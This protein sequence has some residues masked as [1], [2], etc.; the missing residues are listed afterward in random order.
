MSFRTDGVGPHLLDLL[1]E[2][3]VIVQVEDGAAQAP[4]GQGVAHGAL[5]V[6]H[7]P[8]FLGVHQG[9]DRNLP[10][11]H[12]VQG[13]EDPEDVHPGLGGVAHEAVGEIV[14]V[15]P[16]A[17][18]VLAAEQHTG[19]GLLQDALDGADALPGVV[20]QE[21]VGGVEGGAP[22]DLDGPVA[23]LVHALHEGN[24]VL[25]THAGGQQRLVPVPKG[26]VGEFDGIFSG[27]ELLLSL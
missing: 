24:D 17:H 25:G 7:E 27:H 14:G 5:E 18:Q 10:V 12:V 3:H 19:G 20:A 23:H 16:V 4:L 8:F 26:G 13:V 22:P 1:G 15:V 6:G 11:A 21:A 2:L 9:L